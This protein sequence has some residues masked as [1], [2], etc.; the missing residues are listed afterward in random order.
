MTIAYLGSSNL[1]RLTGWSLT[2]RWIMDY[3]LL[4]N[5]WLD[6][7]QIPIS[8][9]FFFQFTRVWW[10]ETFLIMN[11]TNLSRFNYIFCYISMFL[12][13][14]LIIFLFKIPNYHILLYKQLKFIT[15]YFFSAIICIF[16]FKNYY[17]FVQ[18]SSHCMKTR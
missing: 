12:Y 6:K 3:C 5:W 4:Y 2:K 15:P 8:L 9:M 13:Q 11:Q 18:I 16:L 1:F 7:W 14:P 10:G 17:R